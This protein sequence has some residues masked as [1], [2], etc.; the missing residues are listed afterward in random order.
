MENFKK[1]LISTRWLFGIGIGLGF[2]ATAVSGA[3]LLGSKN[4]IL[5]FIAL[6]I[7]I[8]SIAMMFLIDSFEHQKVKKT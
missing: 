8:F 1:F 4:Y 7:F 6:G 3:S 5:F 2:I